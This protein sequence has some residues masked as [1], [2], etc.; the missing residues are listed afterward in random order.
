[1]ERIPSERTYAVSCLITGPRKPQKP[2]FFGKLVNLHKCLCLNK[3]KCARRQRWGRGES[4]LFVPPSVECATVSNTCKTDNL[5]CIK[6]QTR[7][8]SMVRL[9]YRQHQTPAKATSRCNV[10]RKHERSLKEQRAA[11]HS[12]TS[13]DR[14][15]QAI[16]PQLRLT[17]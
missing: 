5:T 6:Q 10:C 7:H 4:R 15:S 3:Q 13:P 11:I 17:Y 9:N 1:M 2:R 14:R 12:F 16:R 8:A